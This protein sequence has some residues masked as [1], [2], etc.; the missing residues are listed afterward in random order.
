MIISSAAISEFTTLFAILNPVGLIPI[1]LA[2]TEKLTPGGR[3]LVALWT[4]G[5]ACFILVFFALLGGALIAQLGI[6]LPAFRIAG[7]LMIFYTAFEMVFSGARQKR[8]NKS[9][10]EAGGRDEAKSIATFPLAIP[11]LAG[12]GAITACILLERKAQGNLSAQIE[13]IGVIIIACAAS[14][15]CFLAAEH[16]DKLLGKTGKMVLTRLF[17][18]LLAA[19][20]VQFV[21]D[22]VIAFASATGGA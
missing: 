12:P 1:F 5:I 3:R 16:V 15:V 14:L 19:L 21:A 4:A 10:E 18:V 6:S 13:L 7:G 2:L 20:A 8:Q 11:L 9:A 17:G 22:G